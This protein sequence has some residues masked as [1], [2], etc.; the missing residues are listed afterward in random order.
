M[1]GP[2]AVAPKQI[3]FSRLHEAQAN[4]GLQAGMSAKTA[5]QPDQNIS[6]GFVV[7]WWSANVVGYKHKHIGRLNHSSDPVSEASRF[8]RPGEATRDDRV[9]TKDRHQAVFWLLR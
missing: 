3:S 5:F 8:L 9:V 4:R 1:G 6:P 7:D 2:C